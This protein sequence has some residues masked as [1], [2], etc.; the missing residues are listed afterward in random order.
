MQVAMDGILKNFPNRPI[1]WVMRRLV[2]PKGMTLIQPSDALG[3]EVAKILITP[4]AARDRLVAGMYLPNDERDIMGQLNA[5]MNAVV[6]TE[7]I[8]AK[9]RVAQKAGRLVAKAGANTMED[10]M[11]DAL[12][13]SVITETELAMWKRTRALTK[14]VVRVDDFDQNFGLAVVERTPQLYAEA[15]E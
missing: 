10:V 15:A 6:A 5:A 7:P 4:C 12:A 2:F 14:E 3:H 8:E 13:L 11:Q 1:A 9:V